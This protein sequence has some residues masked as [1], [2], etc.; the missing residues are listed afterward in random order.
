MR[1]QGFN[2]NEMLILMDDGQHNP[3]TRRN[4]EDAFKRIVEYS[5]PGDVV[6]IHYSGHGSRVVDTSGDEDDGYD[7]TI[8]VRSM[9]SISFA[10]HI[11]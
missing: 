2:E 9:W 7:E 5:Q 10:K 1:A 3:P 8:M 11:S 6:F 4:M